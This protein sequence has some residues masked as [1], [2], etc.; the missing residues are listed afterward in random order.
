[1]NHWGRFRRGAGRVLSM[2]DAFKKV[3]E[4]LEEYDEDT[5]PRDPKIQDSG[6]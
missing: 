5:P 4:Q 1:M 2:S 6:E 3:V